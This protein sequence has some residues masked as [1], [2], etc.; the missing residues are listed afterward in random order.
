MKTDNSYFEEKVQLRI[1][2]IQN[3]SKISVLDCYAVEGKLWTEVIRRVKSDVSIVSIEKQEGK[4]KMALPGNNLKYLSIIDLSQF[5]IID[6][7]AY[8]IPFSQVKVLFQRG[9][10]GTVIVTAIQSMMGQLPKEMLYH[11]GFTKE[12]IDK[13]PS[14]FNRKGLDKFKNYLYLSGIQ[15]IEGYFIERKS[16]FYFTI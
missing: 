10:K 7:D 13:I 5:D 1:D 4:N 16:Y 14:L 9:F 8:G 11:L 2:A 12:M 15:I 6:L 3:R